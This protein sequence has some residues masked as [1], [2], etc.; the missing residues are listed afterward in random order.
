M[1]IQ[2]AAIISYELFGSGEEVFQ[3]SAAGL[4]DPVIVLL[5]IQ[6]NELILHLLSESTK[7]LLDAGVSIHLLRWRFRLGGFPFFDT[8]DGSVR[9][10]IPSFLFT[11]TRWH[12]ILDV[13]IFQY[14]ILLMVQSWSSSL[15]EASVYQLWGDLDP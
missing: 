15:R 1:A 5:T 11:I 3:L 13:S 12:W 9:L 8:L 2:D 10:V 6:G 14:I 7:K 4:V